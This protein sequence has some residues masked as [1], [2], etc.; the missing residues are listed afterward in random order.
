MNKNI[1]LENLRNIVKQKCNA[2]SAHD[3]YHIQRVVN[4]AKLINKNIGADEFKLEIICLIHDVCDHKFFEGDS[5]LELK[6]ILN[7]CKINEILS[8][9]E[10]ENIIFN[11]LHLGYSEKTDKG[12]LS[13]EGLIA[14]DSDR[15]DV[16]GA[17]GIGRCFAYSGKKNKPLHNP[18]LPLIPLSS[19]EYKKSGSLTAISHFYDKILLIKNDLN[20]EEAKK[21]A[22]QRESFVKEFLNQFFLEWEGKR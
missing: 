20:T 8:N 10:M 14:Q 6:N 2:D 11:A 12:L 9:D 21:F 18:D 4:T 3:Y 7:D 15:L 16:L 22:N 13:I 5:N 17:I 1:C 19:E